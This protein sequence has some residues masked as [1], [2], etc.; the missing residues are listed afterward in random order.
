MSNVTAIRAPSRKSRAELYRLLA[1]EARLKLLALCAE[2]ALAVSEL[3]TLLGESQPQV[4]KKA[5]PLREAGLLRARRDGT[6]TWLEV[7]RAALDGDAVLADALEEGRRLCL[8][9]GSLARVPAIV[10]AREESGRAFFE[11]PAPAAEAASGPVV[12]LAHLAALSPVLPGRAL[13]V[14]VG[15]GDGQ[16]LEVLAPLY[17]RVLA[18]DRSR[19]QLA[20]CAERIARLGLRN[21]SLINGSYDDAA[22]VERVDQAGG[23]DLVFAARTL[24][25]ASRPQA[26][27]AAFARLLKKGGTVV[28]LDYLP[29]G[30]E[31]R[32]EE[33]DVWLGF[34]PKELAA[35]FAA[36]GLAPCGEVA[37]PPAYH[38]GATDDHLTWHAMAARR[39]Q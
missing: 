8:E 15:T 1:D 27:I 7:D 4:S 12:Q 33:G 34:S 23:A 18:V 36:A 22:L 39:P 11:E 25:H 16:L 10:S 20:R 17:A 37:I 35:H 31:S 3:A 14:D 29:H 6:R 30:D 38:R 21:V 24:H 9:D 2:E 32:R 5:A 13:A 28:V 26:A 19:A